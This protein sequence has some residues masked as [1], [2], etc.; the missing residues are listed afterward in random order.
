MNYQY[1]SRLTKDPAKKFTSYYENITVIIV[2]FY[3]LILTLYGRRGSNLD[4]LFT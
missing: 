1:F 4:V 2:G 3:W